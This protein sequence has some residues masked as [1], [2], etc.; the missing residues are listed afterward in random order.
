MQSIHAYETRTL[1]K[2]LYGVAIGAMVTS[3]VAP[4]AAVLATAIAL[5]ALVCFCIAI[6][7]LVVATIKVVL[8]IGTPKDI[9]KK[10][11]GNIKKIADVCELMADHPNKFLKQYS[12]NN[13]SDQQNSQAEGNDDGTPDQIWTNWDN[14]TKKEQAWKKTLQAPIRND[15]NTRKDDGRESTPEPSCP[16]WDRLEKE[17]EEKWKNTPLPQKALVSAPAPRN[18]SRSL[19]NLGHFKESK[20]NHKDSISNAHNTEIDVSS[21][22]SQINSK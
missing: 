21:I 18:I 10:L 16:M 1:Q 8:L 12:A 4:I 22:S 6:V 15:Q 3:V 14:L 11:E 20:T 19:T 17:A 2:G 5:A 7:T 9:N 13:S